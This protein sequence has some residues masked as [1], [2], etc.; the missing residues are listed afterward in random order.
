MFSGGVR[1]ELVNSFILHSYASTT[2]KQLARSITIWREMP[3]VESRSSP[4]VQQAKRKSSGGHA[5]FVIQ[6]PG[7]G[8]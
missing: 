4:K 1:C 2:E 3:R 6:K 7:M 8:L 5:G